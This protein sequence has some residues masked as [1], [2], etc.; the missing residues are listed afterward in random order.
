MCQ[1]YGF[2]LA[3]IGF[4]PNLWEIM[5]FNDGKAVNFSDLMLI[6]VISFRSGAFLIVRVLQLYFCV[7]FEADDLKRFIFLFLFFFK[8]QICYSTGLQIRYV[9]TREYTMV[10][11]DAMVK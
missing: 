5:E 1:I 4:P 9:E 8:L 11:E 6:C 2:L 3:S 7:I 10:F